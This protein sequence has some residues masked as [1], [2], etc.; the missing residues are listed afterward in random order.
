M[1]PVEQRRPGFGGPGMQPGGPGAGPGGRPR[2]EYPFVH[3]D[4]ALYG[5]ALKDVGVRFKGNSS[6]RNF[7]RGSERPLKLDFNRFVKGQK[8]FG[9][10][11]LNLSNNFMDPSQTRRWRTRSAGRL[12]FR[13][14]GWC[15]RRCI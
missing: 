7:P 12:A 15:T 14:R 2:T 6:Y 8:L 1:Q 10:A 11:Q 5:Q 3:A 13:R 9:Q 4:L